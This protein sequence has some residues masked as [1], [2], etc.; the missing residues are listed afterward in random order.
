M[1]VRGVSNQ[2]NYSTNFG[3]KFKLMDKTMCAIEKSTGL[4]RAEL[5]GLSIDESRELMKKRGTLKEPSK[6][7][8]WIADK[9]R[10]IGES[11]GLLKKEH[12]IYTDID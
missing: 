6:I 10:K 4:S 7:K 11:L 5:T 1:Q 12:N 3:T 9:Y 2:N 8:T